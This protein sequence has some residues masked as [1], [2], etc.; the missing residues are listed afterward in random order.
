MAQNSTPLSTGEN[1]TVLNSCYAYHFLNDAITFVLP[2]VM[3]LL[4][5]DFGLSWLESGAVFAMNLLATILF[6]LAMGY[7]SDVVDQKKIML[8]GMLLLGT[9]T[10][11]MAVAAD[12]AS[13][14]VCAIALGLGLG[15]QHASSYSISARVMTEKVNRQAAFGDFGKGTAI[16]C[17][18]LLLFYLPGDVAWRGSFV[19][20][21]IATLVAAGLVA[22]RLKGFHLMPSGYTKGDPA[23][24]ETSPAARVARGE[25]LRRVAALAGF[26]V[27]FMLYSAQFQ[28]ISNNLTTYMGEYKGFDTR[29]APFFFVVF[30]G[31]AAAGSFS[32]LPLS[33]KFDKKRL[34]MANYLAY[35][36]MLVLYVSIDPRDAFTNATFLAAMAF[37]SYTTYPIILQ[38]MS[39]RSPRAYL[40]LVFGITMGLGWVGGFA[41]S[42]MG[43]FL[44]DVF[45]PQSI[46]FISIVA[47]ASSLVL[48][49]GMRFA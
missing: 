14:L 7:Y 35:L 4:F 24:K 25:V 11:L 38:T 2:T 3:V 32:S 20:W 13:L 23:A 10:L 47:V 8:A 45:T 48:L 5:K 43:G 46:F 33:R 28:V 34:L 40:G 29:V 1:T 37:S 27:L 26:Y 49:R 36:V 6:Q 21:G 9:S 39:G 44:S 30:F 15:I 12:F 42:L 18:T 17:S 19:A 41:S 22:Y 16:V 31:F